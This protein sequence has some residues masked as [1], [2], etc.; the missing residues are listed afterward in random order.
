M[1][2]RYAVLRKNEKIPPTAAVGGILDF[3]C[4]TTLRIF[5]GCCHRCLPALS[6]VWHDAKQPLDDRELRTVMHFVFFGA[7]QHFKASRCSA[8]SHPHLFG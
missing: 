5:C 2:Q 4:K 3:L 6:Q 1:P 8:T 7:N